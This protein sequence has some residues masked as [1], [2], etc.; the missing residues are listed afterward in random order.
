MSSE[1]DRPRRVAELVQR[2]IAQLIANEMND[3]RIS[4]VTVTAVKLSRDLKIATVLFTEIDPDHEHW[5]TEKILNA[6]AGFLRRGL[7]SR[8]ALRVTPSL[9]FR[10][11]ESVE[12]GARMAKLIEDLA[13]TV[14]K[15]DG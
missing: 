2:E 10:Y 4:F 15:E 13:E 14:K 1:I 12:R 9:R 11:D 5:R 6:A 8:L 3:P 7:S